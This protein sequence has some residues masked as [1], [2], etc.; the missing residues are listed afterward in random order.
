[1]TG[2][3]HGTRVLG[4]LRSADGTGT[5]RMTDRYDTNID[6]LWSAIT[7]PDRLARWLGDVEGELKVGGSFRA[8]FFASGWEGTGL[9]Q[10][11]EPPRRLLVLTTDADGS[12]EGPIELTLSADG[13]QTILIWEERYP[14]PCSPNTAQAFRSTS[15]ISLRT[16]RH[17]TPATR[18]HAGRN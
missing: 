12:N 6:D 15:K 11:C 7:D 17:A 4:S 9:V 3:R 1:M 2:N 10:A 13:D 14:Q 16:S 18:K 8:H 5:V